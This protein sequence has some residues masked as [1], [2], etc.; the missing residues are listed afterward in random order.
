M[1]IV[2]ASGS[3][4]RV[5]LL[6]TIVPSFTVDKS[7][8]DETPSTNVDV[9]AAQEIALRKAQAVAA[10][11]PDATVIGADTTVW[12]GTQAFGKP[13]DRADA[14]RMLTALNGTTHRVITGVAVVRGDCVLTD[15]CVSEVRM[16]W[17]ADEIEQYVD[18]HAPYDKAGA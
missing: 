14:I 18:T 5:E 17:T 1:K 10:R 16:Y 7:E 8:V 6:K 3:P 9:E 12:L 2:L 11:H 13:K 4:R 15:A